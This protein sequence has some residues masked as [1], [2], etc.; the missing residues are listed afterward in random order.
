M[1]VGLTGGSPT[2]QIKVPSNGVYNIQFSAQ[3]QD[4]TSGG[5]ANQVNIWLR[6][7]GS[8]VPETNTFVNT[9]NQNS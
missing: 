1:G 6:V 3:L 2:S 7:N 8:D 4:T 9:D 5:S